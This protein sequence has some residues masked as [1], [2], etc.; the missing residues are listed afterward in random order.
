MNFDNNKFKVIQFAGL[1]LGGG[2]G[3]KTS[4]CFLDYYV[5]ENK[6]FLKTLHDSISEKDKISSDT[7]IV[8]SLERYK[9]LKLLAVNAPLKMP[10]CIS[11]RLTCPGHEKCNEPEI[12]W[13]WKWHKKRGK[14][15][16]PNKIFTPY[17][18]RSVEQFISTEIPAP[19]IPD[20]AFGSNRA[21]L[22][23]RVHYLK[24]RLKKT[25]FIEVLPKLTVWLTGLKMGFR[26]SKL[27]HYKD[28][29][30]GADI[31]ESFLDQWS[32]QGLGFIYHRDFKLM[33][34]DVYA[35]ES[36]ICAY[37][38]YLEHTG[39]CQKPPRDFPKSSAWLSF[40]K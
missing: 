31:R 20:H 2:K 27:P 19:I 17:T 10:K 39:Q 23:A 36:F 30:R 5:K 24:R 16:R 29:L 34:R 8:K 11:C 1:C 35:F 37:T 21:P 15:K 6:I 9:N 22:M 4:L 25:K 38:A 33:V 32:D 26:K 13:M 12:K 3:T 18:E 7:L 28:S 14:S 40:P